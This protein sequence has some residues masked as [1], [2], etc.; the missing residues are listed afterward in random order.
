MVRALAADFFAGESAREAPRTVFAVG[1]PKQSIYSFQ[2]VEAGAFA[3]MREDFRRRAEDSGAA[4]EGVALGRSFRSTEAVLRAVDAVFAD[5]D[6][7]RG[8]GERPVSHAA[9]RAGQAGSVV[10][11]PPARPS[12]P[13]DDDPWQPAL[14][15]FVQQS[16]AYRLAE[17][18]AATIARWLADG[19]RLESRGRAM[20]AGDIMVLV[21]HRGAFVDHLV[22][23]LK[24]R[25]VGVAGIDRLVLSTQ[26]AAMDL[27]AL[28]EAA[29]MVDDDLTLAAVLKGPLVGLDE[30]ALFDLAHGRDG[31]PLYAALAGRAGEPRFERARAVL[32]EVLAMADF[33]PPFE[34]FSRILGPM[35]GRLRIVA[36]LGPDAEDPID[37]FLGL[38]LDYEREHSPSLQGFVSWFRGARAEVKRDLEQAERDEVRV[39]TVHGA[40]GLQAPVVV[41]ADRMQAPTERDPVLW[42]DTQPADP[43]VEAPTRGARPGR[44]IPRGGRTRARRGGVSPAALRGDDARRGPALCR[45]LFAAGRGARRLLVRDGRAR[46]QAH[47][48]GA[49]RSSSRRRKRGSWWPGRGWS[50]RRRRPRRPT[51]ARRPARGGG[52]RFPARTGRCGRPRRSRRTGPCSPRPGW[53]RTERPRARPAR[54]AQCGA[55]ASCTTF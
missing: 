17:A 16:P 52:D 10:L 47:R 53:T 45:R 2:G 14:R 9:G 42:S 18:L 48:R 51:G 50:W 12:D 13:V 22:R 32:G 40:K 19:E 43:G 34:F 38:A 1:D 3:S 28:A 46:A 30:E 55:G 26:L 39:L 7:A 15:P 31:V 36:R 41:L 21:R 54:R 37:E 24:Q 44:R 25:A 49:P 29:L 5:P 35:G 20:R 4:W 27:L 6:S 23:A 11:W 33:V 8:L